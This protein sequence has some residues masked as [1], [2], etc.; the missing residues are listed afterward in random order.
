MS[1]N[2]RH[3][4]KGLAGGEKGKEKEE[5]MAQVVGTA[6]RLEGGSNIS[7][8]VED[9][10]FWTTRPTT[11]TDGKEYFFFCYFINCMRPS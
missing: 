11:G 1:A 8:H 5:V 6:E 4:E 3:D 2:L 9:D 10:G 7:K